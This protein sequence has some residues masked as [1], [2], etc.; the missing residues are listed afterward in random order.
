MKKITF[1]ILLSSS[2]LACRVDYTIDPKQAKRRLVV[3]GLITTL[4]DSSRIILSYTSGDFRTGS[5]EFV[6][7]ATVT[8]TEQDGNEMTFTPVLGKGKYIPPKGYAAKVAKKYYL[9]IVADGEVYEACDTLRPVTPILKLDFI[10]NEPEVP[11]YVK[12]YKYQ[13]RYYVDKQPGKNYYK[14]IQYRNGKPFRQNNRVL[15][16]DDEAM[17]D[18]RN[19]IPTLGRY[20]PDDKVRIDLLSISAQAYKFYSDLNILL[21]SNGG[22]FSAAGAD[23]VSNIS[24]EGMGLFQ[25]SDNSH[26]ESIIKL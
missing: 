20:I 15:V 24:N 22:I 9:K 26:A 10:E 6:N 14:C 4:Q 19:I 3:D 2:L 16:Y 13:V 17:R 21:N 8:V 5:T 18:N 23:P 25:A 11:E 12:S 7:N 1:Y